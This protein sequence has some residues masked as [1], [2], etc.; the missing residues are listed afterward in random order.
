MEDLEAF[1]ISMDIRECYEALHGDFDQ[2]C[3]RLMNERMVT[4]FVLKFPSDPSMQQLRDAVAAGD[5][6]R[7]FKAAHTLK[8][9]AGNLSFIAL[10][11]AASHLT[12]QLRP[13]SEQADQALLAVLE[14]EYQRATDAI[15]RLSVS[16]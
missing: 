3:A 14:R 2:A 4:R 16:I 5:N 6:E 1:C 9:V 11:Q 7:A 13:L 8:G 10:Y 15:S 12:E